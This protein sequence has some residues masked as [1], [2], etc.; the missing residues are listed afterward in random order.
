MLECFSLC[1]QGLCGWFEFDFGV[2]FNLLVKSLRKHCLDL[3]EHY[4]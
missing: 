4:A 1:L 3:V 2:L